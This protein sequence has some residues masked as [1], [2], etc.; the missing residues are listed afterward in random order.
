M[1]EQTLSFERAIGRPPNARSPAGS[2]VRRFR[3]LGVSVGQRLAL[4][5]PGHFEDAFLCRFRELFIGTSA[6][7]EISCD[8]RG[9]VPS[10]VVKLGGDSLQHSN[11]HRS[12]SIY[13]HLYRT[14]K[15]GVAYHTAAT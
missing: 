9:L 6:V 14:P 5:V 13:T 11:V 4:L 3:S 10:N 12:A 8:S 1:I 7:V 2:R 15:G